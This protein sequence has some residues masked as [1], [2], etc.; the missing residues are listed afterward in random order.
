MLFV[1]IFLVIDRYVHFSNN[2]LTDCTYIFVVHMYELQ[3][4]R[5]FENLK[6][7]LL[8]YVLQR[9]MITLSILYQNNL[10]T[11]TYIT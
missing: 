8:K 5:L 9:F 7:V 4:S 6:V 10:Y 3:E 1:F 11:S 2:P